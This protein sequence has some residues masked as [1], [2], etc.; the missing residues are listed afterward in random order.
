MDKVYWEL[1][2]QDD[3]GNRAIIDKYDSE[4]KANKVLIEFEESKH[5]QVYWVNKITKKDFF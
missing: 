5:K 4:E 3:N 2:R 1:W